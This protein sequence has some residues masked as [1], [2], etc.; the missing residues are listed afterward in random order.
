MSSS[1]RGRPCMPE[2]RQK[3]NKKTINITDSLDDRLQ[4]LSEDL[5]IP[6]ATLMGHL[7]DFGCKHYEFR[8]DRN[9]PVRLIAT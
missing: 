3:R 6:K 2:E 4:R 7:L 9:D 8:L 5:N 1:N